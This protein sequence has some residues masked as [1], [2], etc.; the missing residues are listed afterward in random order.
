QAVSRGVAWLLTNTDRGTRFDPTPIGFYF[1]MLWAFERLY[2][3][4]FTVAA[5][6]AV[7]R[8]DAERSLLSGNRPDVLSR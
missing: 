4:I 8:T 2:P 3:L 1:A 5:L 6:E 7:N